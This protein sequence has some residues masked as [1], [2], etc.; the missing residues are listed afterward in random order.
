MSSAGDHLRAYLKL[1][2]V[3][4]L[5]TVLTNI[6]AGAC[7]AGA[8]PS[9]RDLAP[10]WIAI[11]FFYLAG[12]F[13]NDAFDLEFDRRHRPERPIPAGVLSRR[14][15]MVAGFL[16]LLLGAAIAVLWSARQGGS[17][18]KTG[19]V[20]VAL[21]A[22]ILYYDYFHK[23]ISYGPLI[24][25]LCRALVY[26][27]A[28]FIFTTSLQW[29]P[30]IGGVLLFIYMTGLT[31]LARREHLEESGG[32]YS[33][34][35]LLAPLLIS[36]YSLSEETLLVGAPF[37][38]WTLY[39]AGV[40]LRGRSDAKQRGIGHLLAGICL[41]DAMMIASASAALGY[42]ILSLSAFLITLFLHRVVAGT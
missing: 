10:A 31:E 41:L 33:I 12:M 1:G 20:G 37:L 3:S 36:V 14:E 29:E 26:L 7:L 6:V 2:R 17:E 30:V 11:S 4:N 21:I 5:P 34:A 35:L 38:I 8:I 24:M 9:L 22:A 16:F 25:A 39:S 18:I 23:S 13:L 15:V 42:V 40:F 19:G 27:M 28:A 32:G